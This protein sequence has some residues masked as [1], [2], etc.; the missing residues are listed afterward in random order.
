MKKRLLDLLRFSNP[1]L[2]QTSI[3]KGHLASDLFPRN[4]IGNMLSPE[5][6]SK[7]TVIIGPRQAGK[8]TIGKM[9]CNQLI[10]NNRFQELLL[11]N[12]DEL[13][14]REWLIDPL[15]IR[16]AI[17]VLN[18]KKPI[19]FIDEVQ[20]LTNPGLLLKSIIDLRLPIKIIAS[21]S[22]QLEIKSKVQEH[23]TGRQI[24]FVILPLSYTETQQNPYSLLTYGC[25]PGIVQAQN[26]NLLLEQLY[27]E[28]FEKDLIQFLRAKNP[29]VIQKLLSLIAHSSGH[30]VNYQQLATDSQVSAH[31]I[32]VYLDMLEKTFVLAKITPFVGNKRKEITT[33]PIYYFIDNG[34]RNQ[35][36]RNFLALE[37]RYD[38]GLLI[39]SAVLQEILKFKHHNNIACNIYFWRTQSG[40]EIDFILYINDYIFFP[41][42]AKHQSMQRPKITKG[43]R[44]FLQAYKPRTGFVITSDLLATETFEETTVY[45]IPFENIELMFKNILQHAEIYNL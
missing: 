39:E 30:L 38:L 12:C 41:I 4:Q 28:Y 14:I 5:W 43:Y 44:S 17:E 32:K 31:D 8:T 33:N 9:L 11:L 26:K 2:E 35:A 37:S 23:L 13:L 18:L 7:C 36:L 27:T 45:F 22:S 15:A 29:L 20:R 24:E 10:E 19:F 3:L 42:E 1:W 16:E 40:A 21:G 6:D 25:Y 34:F